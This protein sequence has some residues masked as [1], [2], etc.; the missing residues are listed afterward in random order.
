LRYFIAGGAGFIGS[1]IAKRIFKEEPDAEVTIYDN[2][3]SG[4]TDFLIGIAG[5][6]KLTVHTGDIEDFASLCESMRGTDIVIHLASNPDI[7][8]ALL[9]PTIDFWQGTFLTQCVL[10]AM[11]VTGIK[12]ILYASGSGMYGENPKVSFHEN[13]SPLQPISTYGASKLA[14]EA[15]ICSYCNMFDIVGRSFR[16]ANVVGKN[17]THGVAFDFIRKLK[18]DPSQLEVWGNG[19]QTKS[20]I[21]VGDVMDA[22]FLV[23][24]QCKLRY[25]VFNVATED[26]I[27][28]NF[29]ANMVA[30][31]MELKPEI[32]YTGGDRGFKGDVPDI[33]MNSAKIREFYGWKNKLTS[34]Q[35]MQKSIKE[36]LETYA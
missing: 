16:F 14:G 10:E 25:D 12:K 17:Q 35:A 36:M 19:K 13:Y 20:Y 24:K 11:R 1:N 2:F 29:I 18:A 23:E 34:R 8:K 3:S 31:E 22:I 33:T 26:R 28:V 9:D 6:K 21:H 30:N 7:A 32:K 5:D 27:D 15:L 4:K